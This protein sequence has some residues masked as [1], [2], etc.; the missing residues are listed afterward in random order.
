M[1]NG[2]LVEL[3][4][5]MVLAVEQKY[6]KEPDGIGACPVCWRV[7]PPCGC[8]EEGTADPGE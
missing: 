5:T 2:H 6:G 8:A 4:R 3:L 1:A 7:W